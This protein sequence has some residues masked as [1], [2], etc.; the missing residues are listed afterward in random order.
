MQCAAV[1]KSIKNPRDS[2]RGVVSLGGHFACL[3]RGFDFYDE[4]KSESTPRTLTLHLV[5]DI[6][7]L[8]YTRHPKPLSF[9]SHG[10]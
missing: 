7:Y 3:C 9:V 8:P 10:F 1:K 5:I 4:K 2:V 6:S